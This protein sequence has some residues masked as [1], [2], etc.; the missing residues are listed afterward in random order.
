MGSTL[1]IN[2]V[3]SP[4]FEKSIVGQ[5]Y[6]NGVLLSI[7]EL[8]QMTLENSSACFDIFRS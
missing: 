1:K 3:A 2:T 6:V 4:L 7:K 8:R 5:L